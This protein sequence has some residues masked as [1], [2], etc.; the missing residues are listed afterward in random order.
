MNV[1]ELIRSHWA[2]GD[3]PVFEEA[4]TMINPVTGDVYCHVGMTV[5]TITF[6][7]VPVRIAGIGYVITHPEH[8]HRGHMHRLMEQAHERAVELGLS[9]AVLNSGHNGLYEPMGYFRPGQLPFPWMVKPLSHAPWPS[10]AAVI[11]DLCGTW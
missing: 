11:V 3:I 8:Q 2:D 10:S 5:R 4:R 1:Q 9:Y 7:E 6:N